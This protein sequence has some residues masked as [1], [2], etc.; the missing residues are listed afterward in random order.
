MILIFL[1][2]SI[3]SV[4]IVFQRHITISTVGLAPRIRK[5]ADEDLQVGLAVSLHQATD[6][7][8][9]KLMPVNQRYS[10]GELLDSCKYY[11]SK[12]NR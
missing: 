1:V 10:I 7:K 3:L 6:E 5:L 2:N 9:S 8:R 11:I 4:F 12:T